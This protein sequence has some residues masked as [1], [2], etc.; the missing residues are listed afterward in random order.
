M[1]WILHK[2]ERMYYRSSGFLG[3]FQDKS[4][5]SF[6]LPHTLPISI[7]SWYWGAVSCALHPT[8]MPFSILYTLYL[9]WSAL[10]LNPIPGTNLFPLASLGSF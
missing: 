10:H 1:G 2:K 5:S 4:S 6:L 3:E 8:V 9:L 7:P